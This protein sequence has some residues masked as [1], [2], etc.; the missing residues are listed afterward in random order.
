MMDLRR[1][2]R[3]IVVTRIP[4]VSREIDRPAG[5]GSHSFLRCTTV[6]V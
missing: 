1:D 3:K 2:Q 5:I 4:G 6:K